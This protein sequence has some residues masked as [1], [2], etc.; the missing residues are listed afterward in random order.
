LQ[1]KADE[2]SRLMIENE[3]LKAVLDELKRKASDVELDALREEYQQRVSAA[4]RKVR[5][6][7]FVFFTLWVLTV[8]LENTF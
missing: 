8:Q 6:F 7:F 1:L 5:R 2:I 3:E 4:E